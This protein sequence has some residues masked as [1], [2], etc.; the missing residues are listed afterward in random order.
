M[1]SDK[2]I[3]TYVI[4]G[5]TSGI[6]RAFLESIAPES[7]VFAGYRNESHKAELDAIS[8]NI[9]PFYVDY[10]KPET[11]KNA[12]EFILSKTEKIDRL[13]NIAGCVVAGPIEK[14][15]ISEI[16]HQFDVNVF[17]HL[18][19]SQRL[20]DKLEGGRIIN[21][22][23]MASFGVFPFVAPYC[24]SKRTLDMLFNSML[25]E[26]K[27]NIEIVSVKPG[28]IATP[29]WEKSIDENSKYFDKY[30]DFA[31]EMKYLV[32]NA[33]SNGKCGLNVQKVVEV[34]KKADNLKKPKLSYTVGA[35]A[36]CASL[37]SALPQWLI[38]K[39]IRL[40]IKLKTRRK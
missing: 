14:I 5:S 4:T 24:A 8:E 23:S 25:L 21:I 10:A 34:I 37:V 32:N 13:I 7:I 9:Y 39:M 31:G 2:S 19:L 12:A 20:L 22:S 17:G 36:F 18:E 16:R 3:K 26:T 27:R 29:L 35:D 15:E 30:G 38:N 1:E 28:V 6:G 11:I 40:G 33:K